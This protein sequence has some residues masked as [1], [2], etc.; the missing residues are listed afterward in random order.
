[1]RSAGDQS[2]VWLARPPDDLPFERPW[3]RDGLH[4]AALSQV[5]CDLFDMPGRSPS[6]AEELLR[7]M[8]A[9]PDAAR[10]D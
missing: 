2:I 7:Y 4:Y 5:A 6:E 9:Q 3:E 10:A 8:K 1:M